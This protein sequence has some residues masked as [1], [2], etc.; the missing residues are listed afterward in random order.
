[1]MPG[2]HKIIH[3]PKPLYEEVKKFVSKP[4]APYETV[5]GLCSNAGRMLIEHYNL[6][7][8]HAGT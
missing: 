6:R 3:M 2:R 7:E 1:M 5:G 8:K 4:N